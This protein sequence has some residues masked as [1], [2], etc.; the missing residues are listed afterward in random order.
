MKKK[1]NSKNKTKIDVKGWR[2][3]WTWK[4]KWINNL[5]DFYNG[6]FIVCVNTV[7]ATGKS[8]KEPR[9]NLKK[10]N[11]FAISEMLNNVTDWNAHEKK[12]ELRALIGCEL[13]IEQI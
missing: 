3:T 10:K 13:R 6:F 7:N 1:K 12:S 4:R 11:G 2:K 8:A 5:L 9:R